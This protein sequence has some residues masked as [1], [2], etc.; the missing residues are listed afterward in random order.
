MLLL[1][2]GG[3]GK[4]KGKGAGGKA[5]QSHKER[6]AEV[7]KPKP[8]LPCRFF[9]NGLCKNVSEHHLCLVVQCNCLIP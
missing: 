9:R 1:G 2:G 3:I 5:K 7:S 6:A 8:R 4:K